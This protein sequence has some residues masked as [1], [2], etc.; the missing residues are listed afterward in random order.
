[1]AIKGW[2]SALEETLEE[3]KN[4]ASNAVSSVRNR[5]QSNNSSRP[6]VNNFTSNVN[7][8]NGFKSFA[9][10]F[11]QSYDNFVSKR[12]EDAKKTQ[13]FVNE[14]TRD[15][16][17]KVKSPEVQR[18]SAKLVR[19][20]NLIGAGSVVLDEIYDKD[21]GPAQGVQSIEGLVEGIKRDP[22]ALSITRGIAEAPE[23]FRTLGE[24]LGNEQVGEDI[25]YGVRGAYNITGVNALNRAG[26]SGK[27]TQQIDKLNEPTTA[28]QKRAQD[29]GQALYGTLITLPLGGWP[30]V[31]KR[32]LTGTT[33][34]LAFGTVGTITTQGRLPT[35]KELGEF[36]INGLENSWQ[37]AFTDAALNFGLGKF[38]T[39]KLA[40]NL[41]NPTD[42][43]TMFLRAMAEV[44][45]ENTLWTLMD[46]LDG[47]EQRDFATA[48][49]QNLPGAV[50]GNIIGAGVQYGSNKV[51]EKVFTPENLNMAQAA[52]FKTADEFMYGAEN[53]M[54]QGSPGY[55]KPD[56]FIPGGKP[57]IPTAPADVP[58]MNAF[59]QAQQ[60]V[61]NGDL[62]TLDAIAKA[63]PSDDSIQ[64]L[65]NSV[66]R[67]EI[68]VQ[69]KMETEDIAVAQEPEI[70]PVQVIRDN[71]DAEI[72][73]NSIQNA[74]D[75]VAAP[76]PE[77]I[78]QQQELQNRIL[79]EV[80]DK[81]TPS[82]R[83]IAKS[84]GVREEQINR[85][86]EFQKTEEY[87]KNKEKIAETH[88]KE[89]FKP[90]EGSDKTI[91]E[92]VIEDTK[93]GFRA[94]RVIRDKGNDY[95]SKTAK[96]ITEMFDRFYGIRKH[97]E[98]FYRDISVIAGG[99][100]GRIEQI[101]N[102]HIDPIL[103]P[104]KTKNK[105]ETAEN[106]EDFSVFLGLQR[107]LELT[108]DRGFKRRYTAEQ[109]E[110]GLLALENKLGPEAIALM[111]K[112][113]T[114]LRAFLDGVLQ[115]SV[116]SGLVSQDAYD[117]IKDNNKFY[118]TIQTLGQIERRFADDGKPFGGSQTFNQAKQ[119]I[120]KEIGD[121][122]SQIASPLESTLEYV[123]RSLDQIDKNGILL[124]FVNRRGGYWDGTMDMKLGD[125]PIAIPLRQAD[126]VK[127]RIKLNSEI[128]E[129]RPI[130]RKLQRF[131]S[132]RNKNLKKLDQQIKELNLEGIDISLKPESV[133]VNK[134]RLDRVLENRVARLNKLDKELD[135]LNIG[136]LNLSLQ[137]QP[138]VA[139]PTEYFK[140][141]GGE[142][143]SGKPQYTKV[144]VAPRIKKVIEQLISVD[145]AEL[146][147]IN[148][149][150]ENTEGKQ[151]KLIDEIIDIK[152]S[153][154]VQRFVDELV[155][156]PSNEIA[157]IQSKIKT[158][159]GK[160]SS[161]LE[162]ITKLSDE[163]QSVKEDII[164]MRIERGE[165][166]DIK[167]APE[168]MD[169]INVMRDGIR[170]DWAVPTE[171]ATAIKGLNAK[172]A[173]WIL[174][175][176]F[177]GIN[178]VFKGFYTAFDP[179]FI[180]TNPARD[181]SDAMSSELIE[182]G[183]KSGKQFMQ[184][185]LDGFV[186]SVM[187]NDDYQAWKLAG[188]GGSTYLS[189]NP[190]AKPEDV[191]S[192]IGFRRDAKGK[193][194]DALT[195]PVQS[196]TEIFEAISRVTEEGTRVAKFIADLKAAGVDVKDLE[197]LK[198]FSELPESVRDAAFGSRRITLDFSAGG[199]L[200]RVLNKVLLFFNPRLLGAAKNVELLKNNPARYATVM[201]LKVGVP[202]LA[203]HAW[204]SQFED[205]KDI[206][207]FE[208]QDNMVLLL[209][210]R[211]PQ[212]AEEGAPLVALKFP[213]G[214][215]D[216]PIW[217]AMVE[218][219][220][221][222]FDR[223]PNSL[224]E[225]FQGVMNGVSPITLPFDK[226]GARQ[227]ANELTP[228]LL[229]IP[230][231]LSTNTNMYTG[232]P[233]EPDYIDGMQ[234]EDVPKGLRSAYNTGPTAEALGYYLGG[235]SPAQYQY[236][237]GKFGGPAKVTTAI[238][239]TLLGDGPSS[240]TEIP[241]VR[242]YAGVRGGQVER[243]EKKT[244]KAEEEQIL[245]EELRGNAPEFSGPLGSILGQPNK[246]DASVGGKK[247][248]SSE[249]RSLPE[250]TEELS[251]LYKDAQSTIKGYAEKKT[252][253]EY[254]DYK[255]SLKQKRELQDLEDEYQNALDMQEQIQERFPK[256][257]YE[258]GLNIYGEGS[259]QGVEN[260][261]NWAVEQ[262]R[263]VETV[264]DF[265]K[266]VN[267]LWESGVLTGRS[268]GTVAYIKEQFGIDLSRYTGDDASTK[269]SAGSG[270]GGSSKSLKLSVSAPNYSSVDTNF[271]L[272]GNRISLPDISPESLDV[273]GG[274]NLRQAPT[275]SGQSYKPTKISV[276][277]LPRMRNVV[278]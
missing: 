121:S 171:M 200:A 51:G 254:G 167:E 236:L 147:R 218:M 107:Q 259:Q 175:N 21:I 221:F 215:I 173:G 179:D 168:G 255:S 25:G 2:K 68:D 6:S 27:T 150:I 52:L 184:S 47:D 16:V 159:E 72:Q 276:G 160:A 163:L 269:K 180:A 210:D 263:T 70:D 223:N 23:T 268:N 84:Q 91:G 155:A 4:N 111:E 126:V 165:L 124:D 232:F 234:R 26:L 198:S 55:I 220:D 71:M 204:N 151:S 273:R 127:E 225:T 247:E 67:P 152:D 79:G 137:K 112:Q 216:K 249:E 213:V 272:G 75:E 122:P 28:R 157:R 278:R 266:M 100:S 114:E 271:N 104:F 212:E 156:L 12:A 36:G 53:F 64:Q 69:P 118:S 197:G 260:R 110:E 153:I 62:A 14:K 18:I 92:Q 57:E 125:E 42:A 33:M 86:P 113:A 251:V 245:R 194:K 201:A 240:R 139:K 37:L 129:L 275:P 237:F 116:K 230:I 82:E 239:D 44:P 103:A 74:V 9:N 7:D 136:G 231:E 217:R 243:E 274:I 258:I 61:K 78:A 89:A 182:G 30:A 102:R 95:K 224:W 60:A 145:E 229:Q 80:E 170:E 241:V 128:G 105:A 10:S 257:V 199:D 138:N 148:K 262:L 142:F 66:P 134:T 219:G 250:T 176:L 115:L 143:S 214:N 244:E 3:L 101:F 40:Q 50:V 56:E 190:W 24:A 39:N 261:G 119:N 195:K 207:D 227:A 34:G 189:D 99:G 174:Q 186:S 233:I 264:E 85:V 29:V 267:E 177:V 48:W 63:N 73:K 31:A 242:R 81:S 146:R 38:P 117:A 5:F 13:Q 108:K 120:V 191:V 161:V 265:E 144:E 228:P 270:G 208:L 162:D 193:V 93:D 11:N 43:K 188:G 222:M 252:K 130:Q 164:Q 209:G 235:F 154:R 132:T 238:T 106:L 123:A 140:K 58:G 135:K 196:S 203:I 226:D 178:N 185:Y 87:I 183:V 97:D 192:K 149:R 158:R 211:T 253:I 83:L 15:I 277:E 109:A 248:G 76:R 32:A 1:M 206:A 54:K 90:N 141:T 35:A 181:I 202:A 187:K 205:F 169:V 94:G 59:N 98:R 22:G 8:R 131:V 256:K 166:Q 65:A 88:V 45:A 246:A 19:N 20:P 133:A 77:D 41:L 46:K 49:L 17:D 172:E 96:F